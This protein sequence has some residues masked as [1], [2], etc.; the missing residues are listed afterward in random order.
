MGIVSSEQHSSNSLVGAGSAEPVG[1]GLPMG[2]VFILEV[3]LV[4]PHTLL[5]EKK[6]A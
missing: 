5:Q 3:V 1:L 4:V 6:Q 2:G